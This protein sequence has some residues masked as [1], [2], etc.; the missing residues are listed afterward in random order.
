SSASGAKHSRSI[1]VSGSEDTNRAATDWMAENF[2]LPRNFKS[3]MSFSPLVQNVLVNFDWF[4]GLDH[5]AKGLYFRLYGPVV[6]NRT[7][8][9]FSEAPVSAGSNANQDGDATY[10]TGFFADEPVAV[11]QLFTSATQ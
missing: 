8:L 11:D 3:I 5:W 9:R 1:V 6:N 2:L 7:S 4:M 10:V